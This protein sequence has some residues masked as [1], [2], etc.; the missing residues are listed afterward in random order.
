M[1]HFQ[2]RRLQNYGESIF[3]EVHL[4][5]QQYEAIDLGSGLVDFEEPQEIVMAAQKAI[6][7]GYNQYALGRGEPVLN[8]AIAAHAARFYGQSVDPVDEVT[9]V[10]G[11]TEGLW[12]AAVAFIEPGDEVI[13]FEPF[14]EPY[15]PSIEIVGGQVIP[16]TLHAP[17][18]RFDPEELRAAFS[19]RTKAILIN[20][21]H[22]PTGTV[23]F[24]SRTFVNCR[25]LSGIRRTCLDR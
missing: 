21:P 23:F 25:T 12:S 4:L 11:V 8:E 19:P 7:D 13:V 10:S 6:A 16:V 20:T 17:A 18:F 1:H 14:Y 15:V 3:D 24:P 2:A 5:A 9:V 22:N